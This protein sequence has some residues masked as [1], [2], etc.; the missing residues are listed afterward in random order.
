ML[1]IHNHNGK[2][3]KATPVEIKNPIY[4]EDKKDTCCGCIPKG[5]TQR[6]DSDAIPDK[7]T[8]HRSPLKSN[9]TSH[10]GLNG[11]DTERRK[12]SN[13]YL[14]TPDQSSVLGKLVSCDRNI[15]ELIYFI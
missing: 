2:T 12:S 9:G 3:K 15:N 14:M 1:K 6:K 10:E 5:I 4:E 8:N 13:R 11:R 7:Q